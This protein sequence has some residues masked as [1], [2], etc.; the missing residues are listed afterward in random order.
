MKL[1]VP[2]YSQFLDVTD[3]FWMLRS[4]GMACFKMVTEFQGKTLPDITTLCNEAKENDGYDMINGWIHNYLV[5]KAKEI[6]LQAHRS[7]GLTHITDEIISSLDAGNPVIV[8]VEKRILE[9]TKF[10][11]IVIVGYDKPEPSD[12]GVAS[13]FSTPY[14]L[15]PTTCFYYHEPESTD[16]ER[17]A[18]RTCDMETFTKYWRGKAIFISK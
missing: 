10:H 15:Q 11:L 9:Q 1:P 3:P 2:Y 6:G 8:S 4:C 13:E 5:S 17:G 12:I 7:E 14:S 18:F 16:C